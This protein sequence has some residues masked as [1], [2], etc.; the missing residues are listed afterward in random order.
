MKRI[1]LFFICVCIIFSAYAQINDL[2]R[3]TPESQG[4]PSEKITSYSDKQSEA[5]HGNWN[6]C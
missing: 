2:Q 4:V 3:F 6:S 1:L 5:D